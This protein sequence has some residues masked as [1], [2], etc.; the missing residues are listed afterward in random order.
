[1]QRRAQRVNARAS[2]ARSA[3]PLDSWSENIGNV[4]P[5]IG[6]VLSSLTNTIVADIVFAC[7]FKVFCTLSSRRFQCDLERFARRK[8][9]NRYTPR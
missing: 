9:I 6:G 4:L 8:R 3:V 5:V 2:T 1:M 7:A